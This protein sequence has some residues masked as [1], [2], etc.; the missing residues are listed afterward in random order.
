MLNLKTIEYNSIQI[1]ITVMLVE[2]Q[3]KSNQIQ[4]TNAHLIYERDFIILL[5]APFQLPDLT[6]YQQFDFL[7]F[8]FNQIQTA[9]NNYIIS[10]CFLKVKHGFVHGDEENRVVAAVSM[11]QFAHVVQVFSSIYG[12]TTRR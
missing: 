11:L 8:M 2:T 6:Y 3:I 7:C 5:M 12:A 10:Y 9:F 1:H 4:S